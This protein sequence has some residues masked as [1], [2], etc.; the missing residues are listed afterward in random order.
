MS[1][2]DGGSWGVGRGQIQRRAMT[3]IGFGEPWVARRAVPGMWGAH[4]DGDATEGRNS[5]ETQTDACSGGPGAKRSDGG[6]KRLD[7]GRAGPL[8]RRIWS[9]LDLPAPSLVAGLLV[10]LAAASASGVLGGIHPSLRPSVRVVDVD[11]GYAGIET[12]AA[13]VEFANPRDGTVPVAVVVTF[14]AGARE[15]VAAARSSV[16]LPP[17]TSTATVRFATP[18]SVSRFERV[19]VSITPESRSTG[20]PRT[21]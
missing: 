10:V 20:S 12:T 5:S 4:P 2:D 13:R 15:T 17:G 3:S 19:R 6:G 11:L 7:G 16:R 18:V 21:P 14:Q 8:G 9:A 1:A